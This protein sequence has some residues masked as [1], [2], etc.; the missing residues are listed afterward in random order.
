MLKDAVKGLREPIA[1]ILVSAVGVNFFIGLWG[2]LETPESDYQE[3]WFLENSYYGAS[4]FLNIS[5]AVMLVAAVLL[6]TVVPDRVPRAKPLVL[7]VAIEAGVMLL[8]GIL[9]MFL[10]LFYEGRSYSSG[11]SSGPDGAEKAQGFIGYLPDLA[12]VV[13]PLLLALALFRSPD[14]AS[15]RPGPQPGA[16]Y[17]AQ[18]QPYPGQSYQQQPYGQQGYQNQPQGFPSQQQGYPGSF[19]EWGGPPQQ[20]G[21]YGQGW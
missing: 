10:G 15:P 14:L 3:N 13:I 2:L 6:V 21:G 12:L 16:F 11:V 7:T 20:G 18:Q 17:G 1:W 5:I 8:F 4:S 19:P 9:T